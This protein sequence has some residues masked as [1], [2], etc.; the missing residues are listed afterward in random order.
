MLVA[1]ADCETA[2]RASKTRVFDACILTSRDKVRVEEFES[3][4]SR[5]R[6]ERDNQLR[7]TREYPIRTDNLLIT[8]QLHYQ[9]C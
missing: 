2:I 9:L 8:N 7:Y 4:I 1:G 5:V 6:A 3:P